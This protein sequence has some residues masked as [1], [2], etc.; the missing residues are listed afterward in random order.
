MCVYSS[1]VFLC[2]STTGRRSGQRWEGSGFASDSLEFSDR[3]VSNTAAAQRRSHSGVVIVIFEVVES[4]VVAGNSLRGQR[5]E[6]RCDVGLGGIF[7]ELLDLS[8]WSRVGRRRRDNDP[9]LLEDNGL[10][11]NLLN[12][13]KRLHR[14]HWCCH[15]FGLGSGHNDG[16][17]VMIRVIVDGLDRPVDD[18]LLVYDRL[19]LDNLLHNRL[20]I[21]NRLRLDVDEWL[22]VLVDLELRLHEVLLLMIDD[23]PVLDHLLHDRLL[24]HQWFVHHG[25]HDG[26]L[27]DNGPV[28]NHRLDN[29]LLIDDW[30]RNGHG[31]RGY[32]NNT[33][34]DFLLLDDVSGQLEGRLCGGY[35]LFDTIADVEGIS[36]VSRSG[37]RL[38][39]PDNSAK[40]SLVGNVF[41]L[42]NFSI[43]V[44]D[45]V[46]SLTVV[47]S[48]RN[49]PS[50]AVRVPVG[51]IVVELVVSV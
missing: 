12:F 18:R 17:D 5:G 47:V 31:C 24:I 38:V 27:V 25:L 19:R 1:K 43:D 7:D 39:G 21:K 4:G 34:S 35:D 20:L 6:L 33:L 48:I 16:L 30:L 11:G 22:H 26:L 36:T 41:E 42:T 23:R 51:D 3:R 29:G 9:F 8:S 2:P 28:L 13:N 50:L 32:R 44:S 40:S 10:N 15:I 14:N 37:S 46:S 49:F 45:G